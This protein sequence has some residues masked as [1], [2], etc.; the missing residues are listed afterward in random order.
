MVIKFDQI[1]PSSLYFQNLF[2]SDDI[3][4]IIFIEIL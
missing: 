4:F 1:T 3:I 2:N